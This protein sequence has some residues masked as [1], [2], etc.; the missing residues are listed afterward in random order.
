M[1]TCNSIR[2]KNPTVAL[3]FYTPNGNSF[4][5]EGEKVGEQERS[6][7]TCVFTQAQQKEKERRN[8]KLQTQLSMSSLQKPTQIWEK[9]IKS[10]HDGASAPFLCWLCSGLL[11]PM[12]LRWVVCK[13]RSIEPIL[14]YIQLKK[15]EKIQQQY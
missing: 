3:Q 1:L 12:W 2:K 7:K 5:E 11:V 8:V 6:W 14:V 4:E 9:F 15:R 13:L 10:S